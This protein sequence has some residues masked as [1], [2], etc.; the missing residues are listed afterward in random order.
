MM[1]N[2]FISW[3]IFSYLNE[4]VPLLSNLAFYDSAAF[5]EKDVSYLKEDNVFFFLS[6]YLMKVVGTVGNIYLSYSDDYS[7]T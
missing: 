5:S 3:K 6:S 4:K 1:E 2:S 7:F